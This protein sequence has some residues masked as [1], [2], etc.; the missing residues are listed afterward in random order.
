MWMIQLSAIFTADVQSLFIV[1][2]L[3]VTYP[4]RWRHVIVPPDLSHQKGVLLPHKVTASEN[5]INVSEGN[6][7]EPDKSH[8]DKNQQS[9]DA[10]AMG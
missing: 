7:V 5:N 6:N 2:C 4:S 9:T 1:V 10:S 3:V 8:T